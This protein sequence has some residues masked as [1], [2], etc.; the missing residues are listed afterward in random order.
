MSSEK[1]KKS[2]IGL[3]VGTSRVVAARSADPGFAYESILN[4]FVHVPYSRLTAGALEKEKVPHVVDGST[5]LVYGAESELLADLLHTEVRRPMMSGILNPAEPDSIKLIRQITTTLLGEVQ[6]GQKVCFAVP[7]APLEGEQNISY[8]ESSVRQ[9]LTEMGCEVTSINEGLAV[10]YSELADFNYTG[11]GISLG[12]GLCN[13]CFAYLSVPTVSFSIAKAGDFVDSSA[14]A[15]SGELAN[16]VRILKEA[17]FYL[18]GR[19]GDRIH[20]ALISSYDEMIRALVAAMEGAFAAN[21][22]GPKIDRPIPLVLSG[23]SALPKGFR[24]QFEKTLRECD[25]GV[26][27]SE[28][29]MAAE[30]LTTTA[31]GAL[32]AALSEM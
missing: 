22:H 16:R 15:A 8:H 20:A 14:A 23:G 13:V 28:I 27:L 17:S 31:K 21:R 10:I 9:V 2:P 30:P 5:I 6:K 26:P 12:G 24:E 32:M 25:L 29:R 19:N 3:D 7:A 4:A 18:N 11:I 1:N